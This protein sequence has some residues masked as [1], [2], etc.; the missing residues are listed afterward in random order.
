MFEIFDIKKPCTYK[1][2]KFFK[3]FKYIHVEH[4]GVGGLYFIFT[5]I[6]CSV[7]MLT[8]L[9]LSW[10][11]QAVAISDN[12]SYIVSINTTVHS[13]IANEP[14]F[15]GGNHTIPIKSGGYYS[16]LND[17]NSMLIQSGISKEGAS[18]FKVI[19]DGNTAYIQIGEFKTSL[20]T[21][22]RPHEQKSTIENY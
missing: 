19:W 5:N 12:L 20:G 2:F 6:I 16:P 1:A 10:D 17:F 14:P 3:K 15:N 7:I 9:Q 4:K 22:V 11:S 13:Y 21:K 8:S 18:N